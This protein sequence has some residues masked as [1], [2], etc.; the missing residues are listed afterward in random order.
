MER[1][2]VALNAEQIAEDAV[3]VEQ[4]FA[5]AH[6]IV[7]HLGSPD[8]KG[9][10]GGGHGVRIPHPPYAVAVAV[11]AS[12]PR[13]LRTDGMTRVAMSSIFLRVRSA[14]SVPKWSRHKK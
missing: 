9:L 4:R 8:F 14:G 13:A 12:A 6:P 11:G 1:E 3:E 7:G 10:L 5:G 2:Q